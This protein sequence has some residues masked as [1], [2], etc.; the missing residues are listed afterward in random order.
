MGL[1]NHW[2]AFVFVIF[3]VKVGP[4]LIKCLIQAEKLG[5]LFYK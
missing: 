4:I 3:D 1:F 2:H 5:K